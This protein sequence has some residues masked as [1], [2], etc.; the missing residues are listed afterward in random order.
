MSEGTEK[1]VD[2]GLAD[3]VTPEIS[4]AVASAAAE[5]KVACAR[6]RKIAED[7]GV[8][9]KV[10]GAAADLQGVKVRDCDLGCF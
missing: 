3:R 6:L 8:A 7:H 9:Y 10:A 2:P 5:G 1:V 4:A